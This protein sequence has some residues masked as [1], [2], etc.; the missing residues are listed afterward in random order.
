MIIL[1]AK[2]Q[3]RDYTRFSVHKFF[4]GKVKKGNGGDLE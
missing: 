2:K 1:V 3:K 4:R